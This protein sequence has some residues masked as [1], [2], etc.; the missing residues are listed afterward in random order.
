MHIGQFI[1]GQ[2][3]KGLIVFNKFITHTLIG[4]ADAYWSYGNS[5]YPE[6]VR[7][8][9]YIIYFC[10]H[11]LK[12]YREVWRL[13]GLGYD[14]LYG[15]LCQ[16]RAQHADLCP[17]KIKRLEEGK[18][19]DV[20]PVRMG[21]QYIKVFPAFLHK[22][23]AEPPYAGTGIYDYDIAFLCPEFKASGI[24]AIFYIFTA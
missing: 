14:I 15:F 1:I 6:P 10:L 16:R 5:L 7:T 22:I 19:K 24:A 3:H 23:V 4:V 17:F 18:T 20:V 21:K 8:C 13:H 11:I 12:P 9:A 2:K